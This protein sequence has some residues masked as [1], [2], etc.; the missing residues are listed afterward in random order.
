MVLMLRGIEQVV[1]SSLT[2]ARSCSAPPNKLGDLDHVAVLRDRRNLEHVG[3]HELR[4]AVLGVLLEQL[5]RAPRAPRVRNCSKNVLLLFLTRASA[6]SRRVRSGALKARWQSR[7]KGSASGWLG[8]LGQLVEVDAALLQRRDDL[9]P[10]VRVAPAWR[11]ARRGRIQRAHLLGG[12]VGEL[13][14]AELLAVR[15]RARRPGA[16]AISTWPPS[17]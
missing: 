13:D 2:A 11:A 4:R 12:V 7:S 1:C 10:L 16:A 3:Q 6:R 15:G 8:G 14:D 5:V 9:G 17:K